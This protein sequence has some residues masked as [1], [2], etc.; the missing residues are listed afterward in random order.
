MMILFDHPDPDRSQLE[1]DLDLIC[2]ELGWCNIIAFTRSADASSRETQGTLSIKCAFG[3]TEVYATPTG[4]YAVAPNR[5]L[6][7]NQG[8]RYSGWVESR[9][10][11]DSL[12]VFFRPR[13]AERCL[14]ALARPSAELLDDPDDTRAAPVEFVEKL[15]H[16]DG[17]MM[18]ALEH[19]HRTLSAARPSPGWMEEQFHLLLA[20]MARAHLDAAAQIARLPGLRRSTRIEVYRRLSRGY[21]FIEATLSQPIGL[22]QIAREAALS[23]HH[24]LRLFRQAFGCTPHQHRT[25]RRMEQARFMLEHSERP[26]T[27]ICFELGFE[28]PTSFSLLFR[29]HSGLS[30]SAYRRNVR[31]SGR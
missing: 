29:R 8:T 21:D 23:P 13:F 27:D 14:R 7:L 22:S 16:H 1:L 24:F 28:S 17:G 5:Y 10:P 19:L 26:V 30:P 15:Y 12:C 2:P 25:L 3:G 9:T 31:G 11:V 6:I 18:G 20:H 4:Q